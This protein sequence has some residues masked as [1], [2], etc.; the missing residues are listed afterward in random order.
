MVYTVRHIQPW[1]GAENFP[2][3]FYRDVSA[4]F[5]RE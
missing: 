4:I 5:T 1:D 3:N 2:S